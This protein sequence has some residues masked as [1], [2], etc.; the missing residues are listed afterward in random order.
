MPKKSESEDPVLVPRS[1]R[2]GQC[3]PVVGVGVAARGRRHVQTDLIH[4]EPPGYTLDFTDCRNIVA[5]QCLGKQKT[6]VEWW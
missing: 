3:L 6:P 5:A 1:R 2:D 4:R